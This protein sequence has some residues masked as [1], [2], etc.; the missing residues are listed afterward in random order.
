MSPEEIKAF[1]RHY[2]E[3]LNVEGKSP[4]VLDRYVTDE[5]LKQHIAPLDAAF[6]GYQ[7]TTENMFADGDKVVVRATLHGTHNGPLMGIPPTGKQVTM[8]FIGIYR[9]AGG[10]IVQHWIQ[11]DMLGLL[12]QTGAFPSPPLTSTLR[13][14][15]LHD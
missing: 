11:A 12:Q 7:L 10:K 3:A 1:I 5:E 8:P 14:K 13:Q 6:P 9:L 2:F 15:R 4:D